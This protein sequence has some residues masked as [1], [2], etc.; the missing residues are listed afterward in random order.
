MKDKIDELIDRGYSFTFDDNSTRTANGSFTRATSD[1]YAWIATVE[2]F[3]INKFGHHSTAYKLFKNFNPDHLNG[4]KSSEFIS[5]QTHILGALK[6]CY[7]ITPRND[8][9]VFD[10]NYLLK[11]IFEKFHLVVIQL[12]QRYNSRSTL[13]VV[14]EYDVQNLLHCLLKLHFNDIRREEWTPSYAG[15][16]SRMDFLLKKE[17]TVIEVKKTRIGLDDKELG[18]QLIIDKEKYKVH[19]DCKK[20]ICFVY[21]PDGKILNPKGLQNDLNSKT[22]NFSIEIIIKP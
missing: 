15:N 8:V 6:A 12:R 22:D 9:K 18:K 19:P 7:E 4:H 21:D 14:D 20:L 2:D 1:Y 11:N 3:I 5:G 17:Q 10:E 16:S 13:E